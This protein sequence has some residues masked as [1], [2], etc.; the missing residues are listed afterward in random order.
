MNELSHIHEKYR[1]IKD[2]LAEKETQM[3]KDCDKVGDNIFELFKT[4]ADNLRKEFFC[5]NLSEQSMPSESQDFDDFDDRQKTCDIGSK[6]RRLREKAS[7]F[8]HKVR[9]QVMEESAQ[10]HK[11]R[12]KAR[13]RPKL[14]KRTDVQ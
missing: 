7:G 12:P 5:N 1:T 6:R 10:K 3:S 2:N 8:G 13:G 4:K 14:A 11:K 9:Q